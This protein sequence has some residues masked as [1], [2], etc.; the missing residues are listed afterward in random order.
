[1]QR[2]LCARELI[3]AAARREKWSEGRVLEEEA[4]INSE[5]ASW[6]TGLVGAGKA[7]R[8][9]WG[10]ATVAVAAIAAAAAAVAIAALAVAIAIAI[11]ITIIVLLLLLS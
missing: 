4:R 1:L 7:A 6:A 8:L 10:A 11:T 5:V 2:I 3:H 9:T